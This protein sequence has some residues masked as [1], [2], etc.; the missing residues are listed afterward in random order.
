MWRGVRIHCDTEAVTSAG[1][2]TWM[3]AEGSPGPVQPVNV[4]T[5]TS[6]KEARR[7]QHGCLQTQATLPA[8]SDKAT[9]RKLP[10]AEGNEGETRTFVS[11]A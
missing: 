4:S 1:A 3:I 7:H 2:V 9:H 10:H 5:N 11:W 6:N 8:K